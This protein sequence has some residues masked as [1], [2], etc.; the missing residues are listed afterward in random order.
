MPKSTRQIVVDDIR[1]MNKLMRDGDIMG[2]LDL[3]DKLV[4]DGE[5][6]DAELGITPGSDEEKK[7]VDS[8]NA[9]AEETAEA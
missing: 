9:E 8:V 3:G 7:L 2:A 5:K 1:K 6:L 4:A